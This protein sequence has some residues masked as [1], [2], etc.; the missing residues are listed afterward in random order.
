MLP[1]FLI[2]RMPYAVGRLYVE[3]Y[4]DENSKRTV[5]FRKIID[6]NFFIKIFLIRP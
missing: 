2:D 4:F 1:F 6:K 3:N 5:K